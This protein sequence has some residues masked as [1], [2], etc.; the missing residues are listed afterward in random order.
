MSDDDAPG[1]AVPPPAPAT[2][3][4]TKCRDAT[5]K[6]RAD[7]LRDVLIEQGMGEWQESLDFYGYPDVKVLA[8]HEGGESL[9]AARGGESKST[10]GGKKICALLNRIRRN[11]TNVIATV[12]QGGYDQ[13]CRLLIAAADHVAE[14]DG[15]GRE[16]RSAHRASMWRAPAHFGAGAGP[17]SAAAPAGAPAPAV[18]SR[19]RSYKPTSVDELIK[20]NDKESKGKLDHH[21]TPKYSAV[22]TVNSAAKHN[23]AWLP[24]FK[25]VPWGTESGHRPVRRSANGTEKG[26]PTATDYLAE[27]RC[28]A[29]TL[30]LAWSF[31]SDDPDY[32]HIKFS[33][34]DAFGVVGGI[35][36]Y[37]GAKNRAILGSYDLLRAAIE[38]S[39]L[40]EDATSRHIRKWYRVRPPRR[41][42]PYPSLASLSHSPIC[43]CTQIISSELRLGHGTPTAIVGGEPMRAYITSVQDR[44]DK[45]AER[46]R[47]D[48]R[49]REKHKKDKKRSRSSSGSDLSLSEDSSSE[50]DDSSSDEAPAKKAKRSGAKRKKPPAAAA[51]KK[52]TSPASTDDSCPAGVCRAYWGN[53]KCK[54]GSNCNFK[55]TGPKCK[56]KKR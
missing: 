41:S 56:K 7:L 8:N 23:P 55:H 17:D 21:T 10:P 49:K 39:K 48:S 38:I 44:A 33:E 30:A 45:R 46:E 28:M 52:K 20:N 19:S 14:H 25:T 9:T 35:P 53:Y 12:D 5:V 50:S 34:C 2:S 36:I 47:L 40:D 1:P 32:S 54:H 27:G 29:M 16:V 26:E 3:P 31:R 37:V 6:A 18:A 11:Y 22:E 4:G 42:C 24:E 43:A 51:L 13:L 15:I